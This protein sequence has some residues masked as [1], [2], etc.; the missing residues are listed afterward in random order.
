VPEPTHPKNKNAVKVVRRSTGEQIEYLTRERGLAKIISHD[1]KRG[2]QIVASIVH[3]DSANE[4]RAAGVV[5]R[6]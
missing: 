1:L 6:S 4:S 3:I 5:S 2:Q